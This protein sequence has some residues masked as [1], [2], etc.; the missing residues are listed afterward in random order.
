[1]PVWLLKIDRSETFFFS[2]IVLS[3]FTSNSLAY[4]PHTKHLSVDDDDDARALKIYTQTVR[5]HKI[6]IER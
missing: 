4:K 6:Y 1:M 5:A 2:R 3:P